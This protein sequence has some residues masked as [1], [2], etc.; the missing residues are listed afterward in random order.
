MQMKETPLI[1]AAH[2]GHLLMVEFLVGQGADVDSLDLVS[3]CSRY[4]TLQQIL[5]S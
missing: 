1:R 5:R 4:M 3:I 2:N